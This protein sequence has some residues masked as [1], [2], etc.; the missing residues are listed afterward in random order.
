MKKYLESIFIVIAVML[1]G[2]GIYIIDFNS[3]SRSMVGFGFIGGSIALLT[4]IFQNKFSEEVL[5]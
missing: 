3:I 2:I 4:R 5:K 1:F